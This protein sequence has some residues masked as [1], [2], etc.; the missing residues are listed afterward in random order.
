M[1]QRCQAGMLIGTK[2][3]H[4]AR[5]VSWQMIHRTLKKK[6]KEWRSLLIYMNSEPP[7]QCQRVR[8]LELA[9]YKF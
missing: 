4:T 8:V 5:K 2:M 1:V 7:V 6:K 9:Q 3:T